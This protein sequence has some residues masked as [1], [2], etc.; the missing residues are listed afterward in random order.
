MSESKDEDRR[1]LNKVWT[2]V[3]WLGVLVLALFPYPWW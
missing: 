3:L 2:V 1:R